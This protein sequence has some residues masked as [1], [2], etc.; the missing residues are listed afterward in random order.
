MANRLSLN[1]SKTELMIIESR[2]RLMIHN[3]EQ[4]NI[5]IDLIILAH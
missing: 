5:E 1:V 2:Q 4:I 3:N